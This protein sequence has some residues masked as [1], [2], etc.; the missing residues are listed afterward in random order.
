MSVTIALLS[1]THSVETHWPQPFM[2]S[3]REWGRLT[4][5]RWG[6][7]VV[8]HVGVNKLPS[9]ISRLTVKGSKWSQKASMFVTYGNETW[10]YNIIT[11]SSLRQ[12]ML[13]YHS[14]NQV[15]G[16]FERMFA[17]S[18]IIQHNNNM[19]HLLTCWADF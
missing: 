3:R 2:L 7:H 4:D 19:I 15:L 5:Y 8:H 1:D 16:H 14:F 18:K 11:P 13:M 17:P 12:E 6:N 10:V 9:S